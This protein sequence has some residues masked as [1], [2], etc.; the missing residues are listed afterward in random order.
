MYYKYLLLSSMMLFGLFYSCQKEATPTPEPS[1]RPISTTPSND[2]DIKI[3]EDTFQE[4]PVVI[5]GKAR[6]AIRG[7]AT[8]NDQDT[9]ELIIWD[10]VVAFERFLGEVELHFRP[11]DSALP[12]I[13]TDQEGNLWDLFGV[14]V[15]GPRQ[16]QQLKPVNSGLG[17][18]FTFGAMYPGSEIYRN[19]NIPDVPM[20]P[21]DPEWGISTQHVFNIVGLDG[22]PSINLPQF[23]N[24]RNDPSP[25]L[26]AY[27]EPNDIVIVVE[28]NGATKVYPHPILDYHEIVNDEIG[29]H[30]VSITYCPLTGTSKIWDRK[31]TEASLFGISG[32]L[33]N[34]NLL[35]FDRITE[36]L[37]HQLEGRCVN[38]N[39]LG[40]TIP[41]IPHVE[42]PWSIFQQIYSEGQILSTQ[43][44]F[45]RNYRLYPYGDYRENQSLL[46]VPVANEDSRLPNK[47]RVFSII[48]DGKA[49]IYRAE[50]FF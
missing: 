2:T 29:G 22:I 15:S 6:Q 14:A 1:E 47:E 20:I 3:I 11:T 43:T 26:D 39:R 23:L 46:L 27:L 30:P 4:I 34:S 13:M 45:D 12:I 48:H 18:W 32:F 50:E 35:P 40:E 36:S 28:L 10:F 41:L 33:Y 5:T 16:G 24:Y 49:K 8:E 44:G 17:Y 38:G 42:M 25:A 19:P 7:N 31:G 37:W 9:E 21:N